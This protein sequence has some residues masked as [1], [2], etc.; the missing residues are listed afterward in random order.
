MQRS[1]A[2]A[3]P[4]M[5]PMRYILIESNIC[6]VHAAA[7]TESLLTLD[8][9]HTS[10]PRPG[11]VTLVARTLPDIIDAA[12]IEAFRFHQAAASSP[13]FTS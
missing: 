9:G 10:S 5:M 13:N 4:F 11:E 2:A 6:F 8:F 1:A 3:L 12:A 7:H